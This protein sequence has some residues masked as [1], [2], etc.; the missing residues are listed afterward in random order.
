MRG[1]LLSL[2]RAAKTALNN[3]HNGAMG[4]R[5]FTP[6]S[7]RRLTGFAHDIARGMEYISDKKVLLNLAVNFINETIV[8]HF[9]LST[10]TSLPAMS[11]LTTMAYAKYVI[12]VC[13]LI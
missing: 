1:R 7:L 11:F 12:L 5:N 3:S 4:P 13:P 6:L 8:L 9:R 10:E 2:L